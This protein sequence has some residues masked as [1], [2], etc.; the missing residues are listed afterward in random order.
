MEGRYIVEEVRAEM[1]GS[2]VRGVSSGGGAVRAEF[3]RLFRSLDIKEA[4]QSTYQM[5]T[6]R[7]RVS[8]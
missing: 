2:G 4:D 6:P 3:R 5:R 1:G 7:R 8:R